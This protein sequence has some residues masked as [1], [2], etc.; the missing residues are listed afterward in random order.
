M[1]LILTMKTIFFSY[2]LMRETWHWNPQQR[3]S[4]SEIVGDLDKI[5]SVTANE[6]YLDL[7]LPQLETPPSSDDESDDDDEEEF[8]FL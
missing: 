2:M 7:G 8:P 5:L 3:P 6:E 1:L 4:F